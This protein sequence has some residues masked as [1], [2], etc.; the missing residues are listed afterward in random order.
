MGEM[1][2]CALSHTRRPVVRRIFPTHAATGGLIY[3]KAILRFPQDNSNTRDYKRVDE[4]STAISSCERNNYRLCIRALGLVSP[5]RCHGELTMGC[6]LRGYS[7][8]CAWAVLR[9]AMSCDLPG[10]DPGD[11]VGRRWET[12]GRCARCVQCVSRYFV[13]AA[14]LRFALI[15][16]M[17]LRGFRAKGLRP[18]RSGDGEFRACQASNTAEYISRPLAPGPAIPGV[19]SAKLSRSM[20]GTTAGRPGIVQSACQT[21]TGAALRPGTILACPRIRPDL[22]KILNSIGI[23]RCTN[24]AETRSSRGFK[25]SSRFWTVTGTFYPENGRNPCPERL[26]G[27]SRSWTAGAATDTA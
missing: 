21:R 24:R 26:L 1:P 9:T 16:R 4:L 3:D 20:P 12:R 6:T 13:R 8:L 19:V 10:C 18:R 25:R 2:G 27:G 15:S 17:R 7:R 14:K 11:C 5:L 23:P 22:F